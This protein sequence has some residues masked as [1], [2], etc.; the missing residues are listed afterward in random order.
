MMVGWEFFWYAVLIGGV[1]WFI[2]PR[3]GEYGSVDE[4]E[5]ETLSKPWFG[6]WFT[7]IWGLIALI[8]ALVA[9]LFFRIISRGF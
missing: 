5:A 3:V 9:L 8:L 7:S 6:A 2:W 1:I 4:P